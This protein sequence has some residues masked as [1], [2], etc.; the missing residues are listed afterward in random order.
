VAKQLADLSSAGLTGIA[1]S[2]VNYLEELPFFC[3]EVLPRL[4][5][6]GVRAAPRAM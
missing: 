3:D 6:L 5:R 2:G 1:V 4:Q